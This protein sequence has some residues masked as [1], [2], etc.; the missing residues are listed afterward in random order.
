MNAVADVEILLL[1]DPSP[2][3]RRRVLIELMDV[4]TGDP[5]VAELTA[6]LDHVPFL[7]ERPS[8][9]RGLSFQLCRLAYAGI[10]REHPHVRELA[11]AVFA[12]QEP[13]GSFPLSAFAAGDRVYTMMP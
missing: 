12:H 1:A 7:A 13:D 3:L 9:L 10:G 8:D 4:P 2:A 6:Q 5:E 11:D